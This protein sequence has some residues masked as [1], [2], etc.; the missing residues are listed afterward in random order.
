MR[1]ALGLVL[2]AGCGQS[3]PESTDP[4]TDGGSFVAIAEALPG[5]LLSVW[6]DTDGI[7][8]T[9]G[10][11][12]GD[13]PA[14]LRHDG[15]TWETLDT[16]SQGDLWWVWGD[17]VGT[18]WMTGQHGRI[19]SHDLAT[20]ATT[21]TAVAGPDYVVFG[22]WGA[23]PTD[24]WAVASDVSG[25][26]AGKILHFDGLEWTDGAVVD[27]AGREGW[28]QPFKVWGTGPNDVHVVG[29]NTLAMHFDGAEW[30][31]LPPPVADDRTT[32]FTVHGSAADHAVAVGGF[33]SAVSAHW[34]GSGW[35]DTSP[36]PDVFA[37]AFTGVFS[38]AEHGTVA[39]G[40]NGAIWW[41]GG[42]EWMRDTR[43]PA[44]SLDFH[45]AWIDD[46]GG[47][48]A[49]GGDLMQLAAGV[50]CYG[51]PTGSAGMR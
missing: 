18:V 8:W 19:L 50:L 15:E 27:R 46:D 48:W 7:I 45:G 11:D 20:G 32:L 47:V 14:V 3:P 40:N 34:D 38:H 17:G 22:I 21:E 25:E 10:A 37:P 29:T 1:A 35:T 28:S 4:G 9:V 6:G 49:A 39:V 33:G 26:Q 5:A 44:T 42:G 23:S 31:T 41:H 24:I 30:T 36:S 16:G 51:E 43:P 2:L 13:G 12:A